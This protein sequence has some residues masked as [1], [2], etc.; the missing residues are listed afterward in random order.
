MDVYYTCEG[1]LVFDESIRENFDP[2]YEDA[3]NGENL[4]DVIDLLVDHFLPYLPWKAS[5]ARAHLESLPPSELALQVF[6]LKYRRKGCG[7]NTT[8]LIL[9]VPTEPGEYPVECPKCGNVTTITMGDFKSEDAEITLPL[10]WDNSDD[11]ILDL[12]EFED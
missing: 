11:K 5:E 9:D 12:D 8:D 10:G 2:Y 3:A 4:D 6:R 7:Y 1:P